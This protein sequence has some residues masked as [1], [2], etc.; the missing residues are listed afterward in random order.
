MDNIKKNI[1]KAIDC[2]EYRRD[3]KQV[4]M[5]AIEFNALMLSVKTDFYR[6]DERLSRAQEI[7]D[8]YKGSDFSKFAEI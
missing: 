1:L 6:L 4:F 7:H 2:F 3:K 8:S 5:D